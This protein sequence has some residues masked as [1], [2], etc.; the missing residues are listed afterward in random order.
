MIAFR[1]FSTLFVCGYAAISHFD[2]AS[3]QPAADFYRGNQ[4]RLIIPSGPGGGYDV[5]GRTFARHFGRHIPGNPTI[6]S[7]NMPGAG[8]LLAT[9]HVYLRGARDGTVLTNAFNTMTLEPLLGGTGVQYDPLKFKWI[10]SM[11]KQDSLCVT[12]HTSKTKTLQDAMKFETTVASTGV[13]GNR[14]TVQ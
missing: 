10:G 12:W 8:G 3:A 14:A 9:N 11:G 5:Y 2:P 13:T 1:V 7:Q 6:V 4:I